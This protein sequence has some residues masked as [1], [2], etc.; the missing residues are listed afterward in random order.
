MRNFQEGINLQARVARI[1]GILEDAKLLRPTTGTPV[2]DGD[3]SDQGFFEGRQAW[4]VTFRYRCECG[5][6]HP[7]ELNIPFNGKDGKSYEV[8]G[9]DCGKVNNLAV[10]KKPPAELIEK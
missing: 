3:W 1:E 9:K 2:V 10:W 7:G 5:K 6:V 8:V 4:L